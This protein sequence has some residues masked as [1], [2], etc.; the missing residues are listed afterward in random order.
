M[1]GHLLAYGYRMVC[2]VMGIHEVG[3]GRKL[4][5]NSITGPL[6]TELGL[7]TSLDYLNVSDNTALY[8]SSH[9]EVED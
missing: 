3:S 9:E 2:G 8:E 1:A 6:P 7:L 5:S 4:A